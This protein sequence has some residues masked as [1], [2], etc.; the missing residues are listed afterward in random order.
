M[1]RRYAFILV[2]VMMIVSALSAL[3]APPPPSTGID[4]NKT[5]TGFWE[6]TMAYDWTLEKTVDPSSVEIPEGDVESVT[7]TITATRTLASEVDTY[8]VSGTVCVKNTGANPTENLKIFDHVQ[9]KVGPG[10]FVE[11]PG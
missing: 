6:R 4:A 3:A 7:Y 11:L 8:G 1:E 2:S 10:P 5:A 9:Y